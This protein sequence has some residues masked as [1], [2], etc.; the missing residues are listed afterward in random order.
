MRNKLPSIS[1]IIPTYNSAETLIAC[2]RSF[3]KQTIQPLEII[4]VDNASTDETA[5]RLKK[6]KTRDD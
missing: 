4:V 6:L 3:E 2:I 1:V 5:T